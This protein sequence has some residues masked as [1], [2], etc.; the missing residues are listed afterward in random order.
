MCIGDAIPSVRN[1]QGKLNFSR[2]AV[3]AAIQSLGR[4]GII[5][6]GVS[7]RQGYILAQNVESLLQVNIEASSVTVQYLLPFTTWNYTVNKYLSCFENAFS[8]QGI[9]MVFNNTHNS[10]EEEGKLL[11]SI[12]SKP[13]ALKPNF[14]FLTTCNST[15]NPN[16]QLLRKISRD[17]P[18]ILIDRYLR[19]MNL[20]YIGVN[21]TYIGSQVAEYLLEK[22]KTCVAYI[23][24]YDNISPIQDRLTAFQNAFS[25]A[26]HRLPSQYIFS[27]GKNTVD[28][29][30]DIQSDVDK[31]GTAILSLPQRPTAIV[32]SFDRIAIALINFLHR[33][34][35]RVPED[36]SVI[37]CDNDINVSSMSPL[38]LTT[39]SHP[40]QECAQ[41]AI[42]RIGMIQC[43]RTAPPRSVEFFS[44]FVFG[45]TT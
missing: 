7:S 25:D 9:N 42:D 26:G 39:F 31:I 2:N 30:I 11:D 19:G 34:N 28:S 8:K 12:Y 45:K 27:L 32:C 1:L 5:Q 43:C 4:K 15:S 40:F 35:I 16:L 38:P 14:L 33:N 21:N 22:G 36:I 24:A 29:I 3:L 41:E 13:A 44:K 17:I 23:K 20:N 37:G 10:V 18:V 6:K